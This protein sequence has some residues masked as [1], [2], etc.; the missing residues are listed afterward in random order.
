MEQTGCLGA[1]V[2]SVSIAGQCQQLAAGLIQTTCESVLT[3]GLEPASQADELVVVLLDLGDEAPGKCLAV[4]QPVLHSLGFV[5]GEGALGHPE[6][7]RAGAD[8]FGTPCQHLGELVV[9][10]IATG[11]VERG[12]SR[13]V[14]VA[15]AVERG[16]YAR[17]FN[18]LAQQCL[19]SLFP[20]RL[21]CREGSARIPDAGICL[22]DE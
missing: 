9:G 17:E 4:L 14:V 2:E 20:A 12:R 22:T 5:V 18:L 16:R 8:L 19:A 6:R 13:L 1:T 10:T 21:G 7:V 3:L 15:C 11:P